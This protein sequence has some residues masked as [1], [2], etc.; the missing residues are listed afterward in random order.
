MRFLRPDLYLTVL[1]A[2]TA[3]F[4]LRRRNFSIAPM[5]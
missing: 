3:D 4:K 2:A 5:R 1:D